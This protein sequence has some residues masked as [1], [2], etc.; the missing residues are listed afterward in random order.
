MPEIS[1]RAVVNEF[2]FTQGVLAYKSDVGGSTDAS[3][4][5]AISDNFVAEKGNCVPDP[6]NEGHLGV[7]MHK[8][9]GHFSIFFSNCRCDLQNFSKL[10]IRLKILMK[11]SKTGVIWV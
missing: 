7:K 3:N 9:P 10:R 2:D 8:N 11:K 4:Q 1:L 6:N 5:G